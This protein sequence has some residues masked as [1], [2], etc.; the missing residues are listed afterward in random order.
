MP[1][2]GVNGRSPKGLSMRRRDDRRRSARRPPATG[3]GGMHS[4]PWALW[5]RE[6]SR[7][8]PR[9]EGEGERSRPRASL[10]S[11]SGR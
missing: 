10:R 1:G 6:T 7:S 3:V 11:R 8:E 2:G 5:G 4:T 9:G